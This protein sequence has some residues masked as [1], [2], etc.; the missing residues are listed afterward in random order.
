MNKDNK[1]LDKPL[2]VSIVGLGYVGLPLALLCA[3]KGYKTYGIDLDQSKIDTIKSGK[4][5]IVDAQIEKDLQNSSLIATT[6][7]GAIA[8]A[9]IIIVCVPTPVISK[10]PNLEPLKRATRTV[11]QLMRKSAIVIIEST[12]NPGVSEEIVMP[13]LSSISGFPPQQILLAHCPER[14]NPGDKKWTVRKINRVVGANSPMALRIAKLFYESIIEADITA[15][16]NLKEAEAVKVVENSFRNINIAFVNE[17][18]MSFNKLGINVNNVIT[19]AST[20]PFAFMPHFP[21]CGVG[22]HCIPVDPYYL[23][24][25]AQKHGFEHKFLKLAG[26]INHNMPRYAVDQLVSEALKVGISTD[27]LEVGLLGLSYKSDVDDDRESPSYEMIDIMNESDIKYEIYDPHFLRKST[28]TNLQETLERSNALLIATAHSAYEQIT[29]AELFNNKIK[30]VLD[31]RNT[32][33]PE[34]VKALREAGIRYVGVGT[35]AQTTA[36]QQPPASTIDT[37]FSDTPN[38]SEK[39]VNNDK[40]EPVTQVKRVTNKSKLNAFID[41]F[42][43]V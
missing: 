9:D 27:K 15:M 25:Y 38:L 14:I 32:M 10:T 6:D 42:T 33:S 28:T 3:E 40:K 41:N 7:V 12:I 22:G 23:I 21:G 31:G 24:D 1:N 13:E 26:E 2:T 39:D 11:G 34:K 5:P 8:K 37:D 30:V 35:S 16:G 20:K 18:A 4:S 43:K 36:V 19:G 29:V 17:L